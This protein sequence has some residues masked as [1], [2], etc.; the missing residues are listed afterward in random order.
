MNRTLATVSCF[1]LLVI[2]FSLASAQKK[3][4]DYYAKSRIQ[5]NNHDLDG[6]LVSLDKAVSLE[7]DFAAAYL[8]RAHLRM[9]KGDPTAAL[10]D[11]DKSLL[12][13]PDLMQAYAER[14]R[15]RMLTGQLE[16]ATKD[17]DNAIVR[18]YRSDDVYSLRGQIRLMTQD[19]KGAI[20]DYDVAISM[21]PQ[22]I[23]YYLA[24]ASA[25][26]HAGDKN[27]AMADLNSV[28]AAYEASKAEKAAAGETMKSATKPAIT[29][30]MIKGPDRPVADSAHAAENGNKN[31][32]VT[33][34]EAVV[35][36]SPEQEASMTAQEME[37]L[38]NVGGAYLNRGRLLSG[39]GQSDAAMADFDEAIKIDPHQFLSYH[40]RGV[41]RQ[42][43]G[44]LDGALV[45]LQKATELQP[46]N[47]WVYLEKG[48]TLQMLG[49]D[50]EADKVFAKCL[51][52][53]PTYETMI[54]NRRDELQK[55][56]KVN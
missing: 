23:G 39:Q 17:F 40:T 28:I 53:D 43:R 10:A 13:D 32:R 49:R 54:K 1:L 7:P 41:E 37:Y 30:P 18:G 3:G 34:T 20:A 51:A 45:D 47:A 25:R 31:V 11:L 27:G 6:A 50:E 2:C 16:G 56:K 24:R 48:A 36:M 55:L 52:L 42:K 12:I 14:G 8:L 33:R 44:D 15:V 46:D 4:E 21:N 19:L 29:S 9:L 5:L 38:P 26:E 35:T 22:R